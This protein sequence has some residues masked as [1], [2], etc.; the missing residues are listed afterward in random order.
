MNDNITDF[1]IDAW[2]GSDTMVDIGKEIGLTGR[3]VQWRYTKLA[4]KGLVPD[5]TRPHMP[6][7]ER[8]RSHYW[9]TITVR[10]DKLL[11]Q[12][13]KHHGSEDRARLDEAHKNHG[14]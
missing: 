2:H 9:G 4:R 7:A 14:P 10:S 13:I 12:L 6:H 8:Q 11:K 5:S 3:Q 1:L